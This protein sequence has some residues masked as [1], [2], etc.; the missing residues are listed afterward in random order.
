MHD[1]YIL[2]AQIDNTEEMRIALTGAY[3]TLSFYLNSGYLPHYTYRPSGTIPKV[4]ADDFTLAPYYY[5]IQGSYNV[6]SYG[7]RPD[8]ENSIWENLYKVVACSNNIICQFE[9]EENLNVDLMEGIGEAYLLRAYAYYNLARIFGEV[10]L[11]KDVNVNY[12][13]SKSSFVDIYASIESDLLKAIQLLPAS[14]FTARHMTSPHRGTAKAMLAE[15]YLTMG[16]FPLKDASKYVL[17][18]QMAGEVIDSAD[19]FGFYLLPDVAD[20][21]NGNEKIN[22]ET[23]F[24][25]YYTTADQERFNWQ[26]YELNNITAWLGA[27]WTQEYEPGLGWGLYVHPNI[28][29]NTLFYNNYPASYRRDATFQSILPDYT[30]W[31]GAF[32]IYPIKFNNYKTADILAPVWYKKY[33]YYCSADTSLVYQSNYDESDPFDTTGFNKY[34]HRI[35]DQPIYIFR[36][37]HTLLTYAESKARSGQLDASAYEAVNMIRRRANKVEIFGSSEYDLTT[38]LAVTQFY[39]SVVRERELEFCGEY[40][41]R[42]F[43]LLRLEMVDQ[44][45]ELRGGGP[46]TANF[47]DIPAN[48]IQL[49][50][51]LEE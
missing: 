47:A 39:D 6:F 27:G 21:W 15:V 33:G 13:I 43:D 23:V 29:A 41:G 46:P 30:F 9:N 40:E 36:F 22:N 49:N 20:L 51:N 1:E 25:L 45:P 17:A 44:L 14:R 38:G 28:V 48:E 50:P 16:G 35:I 37:A 10:P 2:I 11:V 8:V 42:W 3:S 5:T 32:I 31:G 19:F 34:F 7:E 4:F 24:G 26:N 18:A 12:A